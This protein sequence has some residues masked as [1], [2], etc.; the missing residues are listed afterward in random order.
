MIR[1]GTHCLR[2]VEIACT[3]GTGSMLKIDKVA[4]A[5]LYENGNVNFMPKMELSLVQSFKSK[6]KAFVN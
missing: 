1:V 6:D 4:K 2:P 3:K 5:S